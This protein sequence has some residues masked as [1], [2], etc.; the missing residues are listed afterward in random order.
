[1]SGYCASCGTANTLEYAPELGTLACT[2]CGT[3]AD[4][5]ASHGLEYLQR[6]DEEDAFEN[7]R[8]F[9][10]AGGTG[11]FGGVGA[12][13]AKRSGGHIGAWARATGESREVYQSK[14]KTESDRFIRRLLT[15]FDL[16]AA[17]HHRVEYLFR[18]ARSKIEFTWGRRA[19]IFAAACVYIAARESNRSLWLLE[20][21][22]VIEAQDILVLS[23]A[24][25]IVKLELD[26]KFEENDPAMFLERILVHLNTIF[27]PGSAGPAVGT[28]ASGAA[29]S[30]LPPLHAAPPSNKTTFSANNTA[31]VRSIPLAS[32]RTLAT[33]LLS[34]ASDLSLAAGRAP[35]PVAAAVVLVALEGTARRLAPTLQEFADE[36]AWLLGVK[37]FTVQERFR[38]FKRLLADYAPK[39]P[40]LKD[41]V[42]ATPDDADAV[43]STGSGAKGK[44]RSRGK[45]AAKP[46]QVK[47]EV[48]SYTVDIVQWRKSIDA[49]Q[50]KE[51]KANN[52]AARLSPGSPA[53]F[54]EDSPGHGND[55]DRE[56]RE[57]DLAD[58]HAYVGDPL[59]DPT[60]AS[61]YYGFHHAS[62]CPSS[63]PAAPFASPLPPEP[64]EA[65]SSGKIS[66]RGGGKR[67]IEYMRV[68][69]HKRAKTIGTAAQSLNSPAPDSLGAHGSH[70]ASSVQVRQLLL[71]GHDREAIAAHLKATQSGEVASDKTI[72]L[73]AS[74]TR[75]GRLLWDRP[76]DQL[77][78][79]E[80]F[81]DDEIDS[82]LRSK[83]EVDAFLQLPKTKAMIEVDEAHVQLRATKPPRKNPPRKRHYGFSYPR[84]PKTDSPA[85]A[86]G[87][88]A[89]MSR[90]TSADTDGFRPRA[91][92]SK[93]TAEAR[94]QV[95][96]LLAATSDGGEDDDEDAFQLNL[97]LDVAQDEGE[98][99]AGAEEG[100][101]DWRAA[102]GYAGP[103]DDDEGGEWD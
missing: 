79:D 76:V 56:E 37:S 67:P 27:S 96:A 100:D 53:L 14:K 77:D 103:G 3:V 70:D 40:W 43:P 54:R 85:V 97:A 66:A 28:S 36:L 16:Y 57:Q 93:I 94:A 8:T 19:E 59:I 26:L 87:A 4:S 25:R 84:V 7:G 17:L 61:T 45:K 48:A 63:S 51:K 75:L 49:R 35:E 88:G 95:E 31:W 42:F 55:S 47:R 62:Q 89:A 20:L 38:E 72:D 78:D 90:A 10:G 58:D 69:S 41:E 92:K 73:P 2:V 1:M 23:R 33:G 46:K 71:A 74:T 83:D 52:D 81:D 60:L 15:R 13:A 6:V 101:E 50:A 64:P 18:A 24:I 32:V 82:Y 80:L 12:L 68:K 98:D 9:V 11:E 99:V 22:E 91:K 44:G 21:T 39:L 29:A 34:F 102:L 5:S 65:D 86:A 30:S